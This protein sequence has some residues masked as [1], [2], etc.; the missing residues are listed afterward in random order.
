[1]AGWYFDS[2]PVQRGKGLVNR[3]LG[4]FLVVTVF[5]EIRLRLINPLEYLQHSL[6]LSD[7]GFEPEVSRVISRLLSP[8]MVVVDVG[9]NLGLYTLLASMRVG[10]AGQ[11]HSFEPA[12]VQFHHLSLNLRL[13]RVSNVVAN[14]MALADHRGTRTLYLSTGW[15]QGTHSLG[16]AAESVSPC[17]VS[18]ATL[19]DYADERGLHR[20]DLM[21]ADVEGAELLVLSGARKTIDRLRPGLVL[22]EADEGYCRALGYST[23]DVKAFLELFGYRLYRLLPDRPPELTTAESTED[24]SNLAALHTRASEH[25]RSALFG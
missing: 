8:G 16:R 12:P 10:P 1:M 20:I 25:C 4:K 2:F 3:L 22:L 19:D 5:D 13:N 23:R 17:T 24:H 18:C 7:E 11:V 15:N 6:L 9:A 14:N 21:K